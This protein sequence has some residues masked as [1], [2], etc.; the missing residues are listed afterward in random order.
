VTESDEIISATNISWP[1]NIYQLV[2]VQQIIIMIVTTKIL[3]KWKK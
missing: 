3:H 2:C 1:H